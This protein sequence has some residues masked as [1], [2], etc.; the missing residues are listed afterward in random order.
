MSELNLSFLDDI[1]LDVVKEITPAKRVKIEKTPPDEVDL[2][3]FPNGNIFPSKK[4][5]EQADIEFQDREELPDGKFII[6]GNG[7]DIFDSKEWGMVQGKLPTELIFVAPV[8][9][10]LP[11][12]DMWG[13]AK[14]DGNTPKSSVL[15]QGSNTFAKNRLVPMIADIYGVDWDKAA[16]VDL[17]VADKPL[18]SPNGVYH[19][20]KIVSGGKNKGK[21][22]YERRENINIC[23]LVVAKVEPAKISATQL[24]AF[25]NP[26]DLVEPPVL[27]PPA[28]TKKTKTKATA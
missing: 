9:K 15:T 1:T 25:A 22:T 23:P 28:K 14:Y 21:A 24:D 2:R 20:P 3:L 5:V 16:Y 8:A 7:L 6:N 4:F 11:K 18:V 12:V 13:S 26:D 10:A 19:I 17:V 27:D